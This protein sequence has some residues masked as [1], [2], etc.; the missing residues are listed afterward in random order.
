MDIIR[1]LVASGADPSMCQH[2]GGSPLMAAANFGHA[3]AVA[4]LLAAGASS[5]HA[6]MFAGEASC[7]GVAWTSEPAT[8]RL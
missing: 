6:L 5:Q 4:E 2:D 1:A 8:G 7:I 3:E